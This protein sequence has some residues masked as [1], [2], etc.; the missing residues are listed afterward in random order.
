MSGKQGVAAVTL[1]YTTLCS[2]LQVTVE[3]LKENKARHVSDL[4]LL[5][6][7]SRGPK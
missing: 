1:V 3:V 2:A 6:E 5:C 4:A 7:R